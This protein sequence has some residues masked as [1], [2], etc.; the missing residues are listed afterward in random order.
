[1]G[2]H[3]S[4]TTPYHPM[5]NR[6]VKR[7]NQTLLKMLDTLE[8]HPKEDHK[9][10]VAPLVHAFNATHHDSTGFPPFLIFWRHHR[11]AIDAYLG[12]NSSQHSECTSREH[13]ASKVKR[14]SDLAY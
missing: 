10:Y 6:M 14:W 11:L 9:S 5:G 1:M 8:D 13:Y 3:E 2:V 7:F 4:W 12:L